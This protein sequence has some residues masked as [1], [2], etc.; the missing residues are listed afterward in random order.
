MGTPRSPSCWPGPKLN[1][2]DAIASSFSRVLLMLTRRALLRQTAFLSLAPVVPGF[3][4]RTALA[5]S[6]E[7]D[8]RI[9]VVVQLDG[10][11]DGINTVVPFGDPE[12]A[13]YRRELRIAKNDLCKLS[14]G[15]G[16]HPS[17][18]K[19]ADLVEDGRL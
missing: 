9:L 4:E 15:V 17:M 1:C 2:A 14:D 19:A 18:R 7:S 13:K 10:G 6:P 12:Y 8:G 11:N 3:L 16:L 5:A